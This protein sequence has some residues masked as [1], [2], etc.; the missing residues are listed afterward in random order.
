L[1]QPVERLKS[2]RE[3]ALQ[4]LGEVDDPD[5]LESLRVEYL[6]RE[7]SIVTIL[8]SIGDLPQ[9]QR[10]DVGRVG[11][12]VKTEVEQAVKEARRRIEQKM[13]QSKLQKEKVDVTAPGWSISAGRLH[14]LYRTLDEVLEILISMGYQVASGPEVETDWF[15]FTGLNIPPD[16]PARDMQDSFYLSDDL[17]LRTQTSPIQLRHMRAVA[18]SLPVRV[19][20]PGRVYRRGDEDM[21][22]T[23]VFH[24]CETLL[25]DEGITFGH[26][27]GTL[28]Q[29]ARR[30]F[31]SGV[32]VRF[33][34]SYFPFTEPSAE[35]DVSCTACAGEGCAT[36]G[37][38]G[39]LEILGAGMV[40]PE[41][42]RHGGYDPEKVSGFAF[43]MGIERL[44]M[45]KHG[46]RDIRRLYQNDL[47]FLQ[48]L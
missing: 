10:A 33:R 45:L 9:H 30:L 4:A 6:G 36:C 44:T 13:R 25:V 40:H 46:I 5:Q 48:Q 11:N 43:G 21:S 39:F 3:S 16:H 24:Q 42:L 34:P 22:H 29:F 7:G 23:P 27:R 35:V 26:L 1:L 47:R 32:R 19:I 41:V 12:Q 38:S 28:E 31:G 14:P 8:R 18:P 17:V 2:L 15:N 20:G 37:N